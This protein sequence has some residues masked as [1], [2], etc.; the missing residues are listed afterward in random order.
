[1]TYTDV[2][3]VKQKDLRSWIQ[4]H[5]RSSDMIQDMP[6]KGSYK[7]KLQAK[8]HRTYS[9]QFTDG[10]KISKTEAFEARKMQAE[11]LTQ[12]L[13]KNQTHTED[14]AIPSYINNCEED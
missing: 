10:E 13:M 4:A 8:A 1:M 6:R 7:N 2:N 3:K 11:K 5:R 14:M 9:H 12:L